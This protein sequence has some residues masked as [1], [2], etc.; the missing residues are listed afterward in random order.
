MDARLRHEVDRRGPGA[1]RRARRSPT[2]L[3]CVYPP[4][5]AEMRFSIHANDR[6]GTRTYVGRMGLFNRRKTE[7]QLVEVMR[8]ELAALRTE[9]QTTMAETAAVLSARVRTELE[10]RMGEPSALVA[11]IQG[12]QETV[13]ARDVELANALSAGRRD[14]RLAAREGAER[15]DRTGD[16]GRDPRPAHRGDERRRASRRPRLRRRDRPCSA[17]RWILR[18]SRRPVA[19]P[20]PRTAGPGA[21]RVG[22]DEPA[23]RDRSRGRRRSNPTSPNPPRR[24]RPVRPEEIEVR[25]RFGD[26]W[27]TGFEVCEVIR[28]DD[29]TRYRL[30][31]RS[32]GS[33]IPTL[34]DEKD[35]R[36][37]TTAFVDPADR[38]SGS[39]RGPRA[40]AGRGRS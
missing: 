4:K 9:L 6:Q 35:L 27:V 21:H 22:R 31:R 37:F 7:A 26:R 32:D 30:R 34:F 5:N 28:L 38:L 23:G 24:G 2:R 20:E 29:V 3:T 17:D 10:Q 39:R 11:G 15:S 19:P 13:A 36:F 8:E 12:V 40:A 16:A 33:V 25:C 1:R 18:R 14:V